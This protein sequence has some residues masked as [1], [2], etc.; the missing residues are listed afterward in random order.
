MT[1]CHGLKQCIRTSNKE[2]YKTVRNVLLCIKPVQEGGYEGYVAFSKGDV[3]Q[4]KEETQDLAWIEGLRIMKRRVRYDY[5]I[6]FHRY[7]ALESIENQIRP[8]IK[9]YF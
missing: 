7:I 4:F 3:K 8:L 2:Y 1:K 6:F 5:R 9:G